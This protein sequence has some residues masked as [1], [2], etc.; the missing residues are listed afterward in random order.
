MCG[1]GAGPPRRPYTA[2]ANTGTAHAGPASAL[3]LDYA[4]RTAVL[5]QYYLLWIYDAVI[6]LNTERLRLY[7][8][9]IVLTTVVTHDHDSTSNHTSFFGWVP[10]H[11]AAKREIP[12]RKHSGSALKHRIGESRPASPAS[13]RSLAPGRARARKL[14][15]PSIGRAGH[16]L[17]SYKLRRPPCARAGASGVATQASR[18]SA[19]PRRAREQ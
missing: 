10:R 6:T 4:E 9:S 5:Q 1:V 15:A 8:T 7:L 19:R 2:Y 3:P 18:S 16:A 11:R 17:S 14:S 12:W 13:T